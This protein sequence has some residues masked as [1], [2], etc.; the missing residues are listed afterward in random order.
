M[1]K[2][3]EFIG[4]PVISISEGKELGKVK[5]LLIN[6]ASGIVSALVLE[7]DEKKWYLGAKLIPFESIAGI[8]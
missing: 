8:G 1:K 2:S 3:A 7:I 5:E 6:A 4:L